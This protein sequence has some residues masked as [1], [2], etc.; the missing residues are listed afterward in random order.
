MNRFDENRT[1]SPTGAAFG[2]SADLEGFGFDLPD[3]DWLGRV[4][5]AQKQTDLGRLGAYELIEEISR[6][7]QGI[8]Y[9]ARQPNTHRV[10]ALKR[11]VAG[12]LASPEVRARF[13]REVQIASDLNHPNIVT[14]YGSEI[15]DGQPN[16]AMEWIDGQRIDRWARDGRR[17]RPSPA[18]I[19]TLFA[20]ICDA[21]H[22]A[23]Q[24]GVIHRDLKPSN[25]LVDAA[26]RPH[27]LDFGLAKV[28]GP[29][30]PDAAHL[31]RTQGFVGTPAYASP[32]QIRGN[33]SEIDV[34]SDVY[35]L[36]VILFQ[37]L[38]GQMPYPE[39]GD[40]AELLQSIKQGNVRRPSALDARLNREIDA[41]VLKA[42]ALEPAKRYAS[43]D[44]LAADV[45]RYLAGEPV[46]AHPPTI[47][48]QLR[49]LIGRNRAPFALAAT[50][51]I[52]MVGF[53]VVTTVLSIRLDEQRD[54]AVVAGEREADS[55]AAAEEVNDFLRRM[56]SAARPQRAQGRD[57]TVSE[58]VDQAIEQ[59]DSAFVDR[60]A[61]EAAVRLTLG[62]TLF[63]L[64]RLADAQQQIERSLALMR[65]LHGDPHSETAWATLHL[66]NTVRAQGRIEEAIEL[67]HVAAP[68]FRADPT[69]RS[70]LAGALDSLASAYMERNDIAR[71]EV[72]LVEL[73]AVRAGLPDP[74]V[75]DSVR[76]LLLLSSLQFHK[77]ELAGA[78]PYLRNAVD[79]ARAGLGD[80]HELTV[81]ALSNLAVLLKQL[82]RPTDALPL[83]EESLAT[84]RQVFG[85]D[86]PHTLQAMTNMASLL[87][88]LKRYPASEAL[89]EELLFH[90]ESKEQSDHPTAVSA[91]HNLASLYLDEARCEEAEQ[92]LRETLE[93]ARR[94]FGPEHANTAMTMGLLASAIRDGR[95]KSGVD[96]ARRLLT[97]ALAILE[98]ALP[99]EHPDI[100]K[101]RDLLARMDDE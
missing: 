92:L 86:H 95:P 70:R 79:Q 35:S 42:L 62:E 94:A 40:L 33:P 31:T 74:D 45:R 22:H 99:P 27:I 28:L 29:D 49:K 57:V 89:Y 25:I 15:V 53:S 8:V 96:E 81:V 26:D 80:R 75:K 50:V 83:S 17:G 44:G 84:A 47:G 2:S 56:L 12:S 64:G 21:V 34:R 30:E 90:F 61:V 46:L 71:A 36:G 65:E 41:I 52:L 3:D 67:Y 43:M 19:L 78:E 32:E 69:Q 16:L 73:Q 85:G 68:V 60:P 39:A 66:A 55:R 1:P 37:M 13:E 88:A 58:I 101:T 54:A 18:D 24:R 23:H 87:Q 14:V 76:D 77:G 4:R 9:R 38:T 51:A 63:G 59:A 82:D 48:Y 98:T 11:L 7:A 100:Q 10:I 93:R 5:A 20:S 72:T 6:G 97:D 91:A